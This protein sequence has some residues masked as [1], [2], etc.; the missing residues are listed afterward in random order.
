MNIDEGRLM[1]NG[2][3]TDELGV[4]SMD[5]RGGV[6]VPLRFSSYYSWGV[7]LATFITGDSHGG[8]G[9]DFCVELLCCKKLYK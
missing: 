7:F 1:N 5:R 3:V 2:A 9:P 6:L 8:S 4:K